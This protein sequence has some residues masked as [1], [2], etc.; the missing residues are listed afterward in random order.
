MRKL[1]VFS[2]VTVSCFGLN[3]HAEQIGLR[4]CNLLDDSAFLPVVDDDAALSDLVDVKA[5]DA[6][7]VNK[8]LSVFD[9]NV[10]VTRGGRELS[11]DHITYHRATGTVTAQ[12]DIRLRDSQM[13]LEGDEAEWLTSSDEGTMVNATYHLREIGARG[14]AKHIYRQGLLQTDL[15][16]A[17]YSTCSVANPFWDLQAN[18]VKLDHDEAV[19]SAEDVIV[20]IKDVP[21]FYT[22]YISF[23]LNDQRKSGFL[24]PSFGNSDETGF[25]LQTPYYWNIGPGRDATITPRY[26]SD[27]GMQLNAEYRYLYLGGEGTIQAGFLASDDLKT[28]GEDI[29]P[30]YNEDRK[31]FSFRHIGNANS[32]WR[33]DIDYNYISDDDYLEDFGSNLSLTS[34]THLYRKAQLSYS[35]DTW[36]FVGRMQGYQTITDVEE[37]YQRLPQLILSGS[38]PE[39]LF[40]LSYHLRTEYVEFDHDDLVDGQRFDIMPTI[41]LPKQSAA[42][43]FTPSVTL[44]HTEYRLNEN[45]QTI[46]DDS[47]S[48]TLPI[49][50]V[51]SGLFFE[52]SLPFKGQNY[53]HTLEPRAFYLYIPERDQTDI[54]IFDSSLR[55]FNFGQLFAEDRFSGTDRVGDANQLSLALTS[56]IIDPDTGREK[57]SASIGQIRYFTDRD[58]ILPSGEVG[59]RSGSDMVVEVAA[60][61]AKEWTAK[62]EVQWDPH[63]GNQSNLSSVQLRYRG[64]NGQIFN[65][66]HRYRRDGVS[67]IEGLEQ[68]DVSGRLP[69]NEQWSL[70]GRYYHSLRDNKLLEGLAGVEYDSCCWATRFVIRDYINDID[71]D[72]RNLAFLFQIELKG[73]GNFG[74]KTDDLL[75]ESIF[76]FDPDY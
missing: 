19:G 76:G 50:S 5:D 13:V 44:R 46:T 52:R 70:I 72:D 57:L 21:V 16:G 49:A 29:N 62:A 31:H 66:S 20:R 39:K 38:F 58:V 64:D 25:D 69:I 33:T 9:G 51:D 68:V 8:G 54:P 60:A 12:G 71:D 22:P 53:I 26:M 15:R 7:L 2:A 1:I 74:Q 32:R 67:T 4:Q 3:V 43:F 23:P 59:S 65:I 28:D 47:P 6:Q 18:S 37:P 73:L 75:K 56:R 36:S 61:L 14:D 30:Y 35:D 24:A 42:G 17:T 48:R 10:V 34:T 40:G 45:G 27:R 11:A 63:S 55:T 41:S